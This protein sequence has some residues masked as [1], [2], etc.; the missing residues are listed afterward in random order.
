MITIATI[1]LVPFLT[2]LAYLAYK[3]PYVFNR[4][5]LPV[6]ASI[7]LVLFGALYMVL[8]YASHTSYK[9][10]VTFIPLDKRLAALEA[11]QSANISDRTYFIIFGAWVAF[12]LY[13]AFLSALPYL[14]KQEEQN[15]KLKNQQCR[16]EIE[17]QP[18]EGQ[19][20]Q[21]DKL[22]RE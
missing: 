11:V 15:K 1:L 21:Q 16:R 6:V 13:L 20:Q 4:L 19:H 22:K 2:G 10:L 17:Q 18:S 5:R 12:M 8:S 14:L 7:I 9:A 3:H